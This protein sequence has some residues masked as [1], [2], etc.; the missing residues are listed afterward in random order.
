[1]NP[2]PGIYIPVPS[3][4]SDLEKFIDDTIPLYNL[5]LYCCRPSSS[6]VESVATPVPTPPVSSSNGKIFL[7]SPRPVGNAKGGEGMRQA[8]ETYKKL[9]PQITAI[10]IGTRRT[11]PHGGEH[12]CVYYY[13][14]PLLTGPVSLAKLSHRNMTDPGWPEFERVNP[15]ID[16][17]Y[18][19]VWTFLRHLSVPYCNLYD[20][21]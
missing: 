11:D 12:C 7:P 14:A 13:C 1:M 4:F 17:S 9:F 2:I 21:G 16:W 6:Q 15:I 19:D 8:L 5:D 20:Q 10:L 18:S 3:P